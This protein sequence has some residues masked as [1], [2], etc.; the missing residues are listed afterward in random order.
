MKRI[1]FA[2]IIFLCFVPLAQG[3]IVG[4]GG[5]GTS[6]G[7]CA[8]CSGTATFIWECNS[9]TVGEGSPCGCSDGDTTA[10]ANGQ[11]SI[12]SG[13]AVFNDTSN[14]GADFYAF[15]NGADVLTDDT[16]GT[17]FIRFKVTTW[18]DAAKLFRLYGND[19]NFIALR[20]ASSNDL[21]GRFNH[22][23]VLETI[24]ITGGN[25]STGTEY[26]ARY[27]WQT[28]EAGDDHQITLFNTSMS[29]LDN[30][31]EDDDPTAFA[32]QAGDGD[33]RV[34]HDTTGSTGSNISVYY[35]H[36]YNE[37]KDTDPNGP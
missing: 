25:I 6:A 29:Q 8:S 12:S 15:D 21:D 23:G 7:G 1:L 5:L 26:I 10:T 4:Q 31:L 3:I 20:L 30:I 33:F 19:N 18:V 24:E 22:G 32:V 27:R 16:L 37:W 9:T 11:V 35:I 34:G 2:L 13:A 17:V 14:N 36:V 28:G